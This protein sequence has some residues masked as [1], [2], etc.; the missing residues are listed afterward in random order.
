[1]SP[2]SSTPIVN[3]NKSIKKELT[4]NKIYGS[5]KNVGL[6]WILIQLCFPPLI[7]NQS[8]ISTF[9]DILNKCQHIRHFLK[10]KNTLYMT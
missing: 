3:E 5:A 1:M 8:L 7:K 2:L 6:L 4:N 10:K 9:Q